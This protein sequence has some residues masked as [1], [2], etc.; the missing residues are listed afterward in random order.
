VGANPPAEWPGVARAVGGDVR[1]FERWGRP[2][3]VPAARTAAAAAG[4]GARW[5]ARRR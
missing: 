2:L 1:R 5:A 4:A 3:T